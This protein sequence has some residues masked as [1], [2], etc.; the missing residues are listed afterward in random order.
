MC[1]AGG[2]MRGSRGCGSDEVGRKVGGVEEDSESWAR[3]WDFRAG[4]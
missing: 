4:L 1:A 2:G 3:D